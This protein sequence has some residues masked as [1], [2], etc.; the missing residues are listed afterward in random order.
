MC[1][2]LTSFGP[3]QSRSCW[4]SP[5]PSEHKLFWLKEKLIMQ[6]F[7]NSSQAGS[8]TAFD[9]SGRFTQ[10]N[11]S[12]LRAEGTFIKTI[13][14]WS[15]VNFRSDQVF[16]NHRVTDEA[17]MSQTE[18][19]ATLSDWQSLLSQYPPPHPTPKLYLQQ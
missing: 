12:C 14:G 2:R 10:I 1:S 17:E 9:T 13:P 8:L 11:L 16:S 5:S 6:L 18:S 15:S 19:L 4:Q 7:N 3:V